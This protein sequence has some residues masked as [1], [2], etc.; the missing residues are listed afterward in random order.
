[1]PS[2]CLTYKPYAGICTKFLCMF[3][4][5]F[6]PQRMPAYAAVGERSCNVY[7]LR[8]TFI[9]CLSACTSI[10]TDFVH[11]LAYA[12]AIRN[13]VTGLLQ[14]TIF[15]IKRLVLL[16]TKQLQQDN[17]NKFCLLDSDKDMY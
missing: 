12:S 8:L 3:K 1:M 7:N 4:N 16:I 2:V 17:I 14:I 6:L 5:K 11:T 9:Y 15:E 13:S 10:M